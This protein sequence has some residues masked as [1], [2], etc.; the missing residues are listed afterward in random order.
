MIR[1]PVTVLDLGLSRTGPDGWD[2]TAG[3]LKDTA[4]KSN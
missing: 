1:N 2:V 3:L 4:G